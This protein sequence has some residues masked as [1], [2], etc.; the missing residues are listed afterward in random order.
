[1][2]ETATGSTQ[3]VGFPP[4]HCVT[5]RAQVYF[6]SCWD[7]INLDTPNHK[8]H[9]AYPAVGGFDG[10][11]CP[12]SH[13]VALLSIFYEFFFDTSPYPDFTNLLY[14]NGDTTGY[15][16]HGDFINGWTNLTALQVALVTCDDFN[17]AC[18][19]RTNSSV[20]VQETRPLIH[21]AIYEEQIGLN[22][23]IATLPGN[24]SIWTAPSTA[25]TSATSSALPVTDILATSTVPTTP[26]TVTV[27]VT[28]TSIATPAA[29][30]V[31]V[32]MS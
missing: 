29:V 2:C 30:T 1:M 31:T 20:D 27:T 9:V 8:D 7:G 28:V 23:P 10:G 32:T 25:T 22:G 18:S 26:A 14:S 6:P 17:P 15:G 16:F 5:F 11:I 19:I 12:Q 3:Y 13:P 24:P 21:P 4:E